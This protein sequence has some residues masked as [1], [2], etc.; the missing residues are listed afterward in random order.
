MNARLSGDSLD[1][2]LSRTNVEEFIKK[3]NGYPPDSSC[4]LE[5]H[6]DYGLLRVIAVEDEA[7]ARV[8]FLDDPVLRAIEVCIS[9]EQ[10]EYLQSS[11]TPRVDYANI[12]I[13]MEEDAVHYN[14]ALRE[15]RARGMRGATFS[16]YMRTGRIDDKEVP[17]DG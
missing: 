13:T 15:E 17:K 9:R 3:L 16:E 8:Q 7:L 6:T 2:Y 14:S 4:T 11:K 5:R 12:I 1:L 10:L